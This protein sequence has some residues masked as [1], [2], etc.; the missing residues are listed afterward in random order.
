MGLEKLV[1]AVF[2]V[3]AADAGFSPT[4]VEALHG[5]EVFAVDVGLTE[6]DFTAGFHR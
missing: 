4:G 5:L 1:E 3:G 2:A 6:M